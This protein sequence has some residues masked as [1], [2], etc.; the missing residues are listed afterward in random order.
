LLGALSPETQTSIKTVRAAL[1][2]HYDAEG[3]LILY[4]YL[5]TT[6]QQ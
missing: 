3:H 6:E 1:K 4:F 2:C 5:C